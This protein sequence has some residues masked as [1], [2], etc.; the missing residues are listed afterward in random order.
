MKRLSLL[1]GLLVVCSTTWWACPVARADEGDDTL[2]GWLAKADVVVAG[3]IVSEP[4]GFSFELGVVNYPCDF[5]VAD[6]L[7]GDAKLAGQTIKVNIVRFE[8]DAKDKSPLIQKNAE[9]ILFLKQYGQEKPAW[10]TADF[11]FGIQPGSPW[12]ARSL[13]RIAPLMTDRTGDYNLHCRKPDDQVTAKAE[14]D[15]VV[16]DI[17]S[18]SG[19]GGAQI[20][21][22]NTAWPA[23]MALRLHLAG[24]E[25]LSIGNGKNTLKI[26]V[27]SHGNRD[28]LVHLVRDGKEGPQLDKTSPFWTEVGTREADGRQSDKFHVII[29]RALLDE[30]GNKLEIHWI[31]FYR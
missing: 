9:C 16:F 25:S 10:R 20:V 19:I 7:K 17:V 30:A 14:G 26:S 23:V 3:Q 6:V 31:D 2:R 21:R 8:R 28:R 18:P 12:L 4:V 15:R 5:K 1:L 24:L 13:K 29:P 27:L 11:W 22:K